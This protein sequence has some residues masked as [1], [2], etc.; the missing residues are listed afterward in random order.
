M[1]RNKEFNEIEAPENDVNTFVEDEDSEESDMTQI[2]AFKYPRCGGDELRWDLHTPFFQEANIRAIEVDP[3]GNSDFEEY[4][5]YIGSAAVFRPEDYSTEYG[6]SWTCRN[7]RYVLEDDD[8]KPI[9]HEGALV[10]WML[11]HG[12]VVTHLSEVKGSADEIDRRCI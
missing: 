3:E 5:C 7:C 9:D 10:E 2:L 12:E 6:S 11:L 4:G 8:G 1:T